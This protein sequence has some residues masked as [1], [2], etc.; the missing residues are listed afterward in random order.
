MLF[1]ARFLG[2][3]NSGRFRLLRIASRKVMD[4]A[5]LVAPR[6]HRGGAVE[7]SKLETTA[8]LKA[9]R[10]FGEVQVEFGTARSHNIRKNLR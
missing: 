4:M 9:R 8:G 5:K 6:S 10:I 2:I 1:A 3:Q 7:S